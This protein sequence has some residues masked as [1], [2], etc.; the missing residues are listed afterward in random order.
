MDFRLRHRRRRR[1]EEDF[2]I[3]NSRA[4]KTDGQKWMT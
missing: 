4:R 2:C 1:K 3:K